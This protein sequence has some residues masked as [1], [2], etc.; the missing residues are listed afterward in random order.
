LNGNRKPTE[1]WESGVEGCG[2]RK[3]GDR[4]G[5][6]FVKGVE[7]QCHNQEMFGAGAGGGV[8][9]QDFFPVGLTKSVEDREQRE[10][11]FEGGS[12]V[13]RGSTQLANE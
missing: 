10:Q 13:V 9:N 11:G 4:M 7:G 8:L 12:P 1:L 2:K 3:S 6:E 5:G